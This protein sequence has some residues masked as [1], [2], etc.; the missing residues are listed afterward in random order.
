MPWAHRTWA[1]PVLTALAPSDRYCKVGGTH[2]KLTDWTRQMILQLRRWLPN[3]PLVVVADSSY[4]ALDLLHLCQSVTSPV[5]FITRLRLDAALYEPAPPRRA[6]SGGAYARQ[7]PPP[8]HTQGAPGLSPY[9]LDE[10]RS[11]VARRRY[12]DGGVQLSN[13]ALVSHWQATRAHSMGARSRPSTAVRLPGAAVYR[14]RSQSG[15]I[16]SGSRCAGGSRRRFRR[17]APLWDW[18][19]NA[20]GRIAS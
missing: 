17:P 10:R 13:S 6:R 12:S 15:Q 5:I 14:S 7:G 11:R 1:L 18:R 9:A 20:S 4:A 8:T 3:R 19:H 16:A 2:K